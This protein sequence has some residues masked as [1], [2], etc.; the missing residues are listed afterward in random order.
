MKGDKDGHV[1]VHKGGAVEREKDCP[2]PFLVGAAEAASSLLPPLRRQGRVGEGCFQDHGEPWPPP[3]S[4][5]LPSQGEGPK[6]KLAASAAPTNHQSRLLL[7]RMPAELVAHRRQQLVGER[8]AVARAQ[9][10]AQRLGEDRK[11]GG[12]GKGVA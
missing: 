6:Q 2:P 11:R 5:P 3:P 12:G 10:G 7:H 4:L 8:V 1:A 9:A